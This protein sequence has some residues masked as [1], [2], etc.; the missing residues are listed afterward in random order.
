MQC[1]ARADAGVVHP[2]GQR[3]LGAGAGRPLTVR[4]RLGDVAADDRAPSPGGG[5][6]RG[7]EL[8]VE[9]DADDEPAVGEQ[10]LKARAADPLPSAGYDNASIHDSSLE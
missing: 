2:A 8:L 6:G 7:G 5:F 1:P 4:L 9:L 3:R 10:S